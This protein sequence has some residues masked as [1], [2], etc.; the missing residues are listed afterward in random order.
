MRGV[1]LSRRRLLR[2]AACGL[3]IL[4]IERETLAQP[5]GRAQQAAPVKPR[6]L[7]I[8]AIDPG[9]GGSD[10]GAIG[11]SRVYEKDIVAAVAHEIARRLVASR[12]FRAVLTRHRDEFVGLRDRVARARAAHADLFLSIHADTLPDPAKHGLSVFTL[13]VEASD[14]EAAALALSENKSAP[15]A[16]VD[17]SRQ[18]REID[19]V[20]I[21]LAQRETANRSLALAHNVVETLGRE[22]PLLDRPQRSAGF[23]VLTAPDIPSVLVELGC[24]SNRDEEW[25]LRQP[26]YRLALAGGLVRAIEVYF[27]TRVVP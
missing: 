6:Y 25:R 8:V 26:A 15:V 7:P 1:Y 5:A 22:V 23:A 13:S 10:P 3:G 19:K 12:R 16:G 24:L 14:R 11:P 2:L 27:A 17:L 18:P 9:H 20:L 4:A 21:A